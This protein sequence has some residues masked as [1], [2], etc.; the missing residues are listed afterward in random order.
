MVASMH[1][2]T[3]VSCS[4]SDRSFIHASLWRWMHL[5]SS[6]VL[7]I[8]FNNPFTRTN[9][10]RISTDSFHPRDSM[11]LICS[12][13]NLF[14]IHGAGVHPPGRIVMCG[15]SKNRFGNTMA[16]RRALKKK[17]RFI[18]CRGLFSLAVG[19]ERSNFGHGELSKIT[20]F[21]KIMIA[22]STKFS[23]GI[24][25]GATFRPSDVWVSQTIP[26]AH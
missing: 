9:A 8:H 1:G 14:P 24:W 21:H 15:V 19:R 26:G 4:A 12:G 17:R 6:A 10:S 16:P 5:T 7:I 11:A 3:N 23:H 18:L 25:P 13:V 2:R 20:D 22:Y